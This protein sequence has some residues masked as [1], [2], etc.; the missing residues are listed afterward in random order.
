MADT[1][2]AQPTSAKATFMGT[3]LCFT[4]KDQSASKVMDEHQSVISL[5]VGDGVAHHTQAGKGNTGLCAVSRQ[6]AE[7]V[8]GSLGLSLQMVRAKC[9]AIRGREPCC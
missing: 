4:Q 1:T 3:I 7:L 9:D 5:Q 6:A 8:L 2:S